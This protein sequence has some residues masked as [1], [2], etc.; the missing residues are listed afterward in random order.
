MAILPDDKD[1]TWVLTIR[2]PECGFDPAAVERAGVGAALRANVSRW[3]PLLAHPA[4]AVRPRDDRWSALE[5]GCHVRDVFRRFDQ[6][7]DLLLAVDDP[8][9]ENWDQDATAVT[10]RYGEQDPVAV[11]VALVEAGTALAD[12]FDGVPPDAWTRSGSRSDGAR[13]TVETFA[14]YLLHDPVHHVWDVEEGYRALG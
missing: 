6:R 13:F 3:G 10:D 5:Y 1:W 14:T 12:R 8:T 9:F 2:C 4:V 7:L 11:G